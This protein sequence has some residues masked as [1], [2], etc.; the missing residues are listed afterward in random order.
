MLLC[1]F[2][3]RCLC[4]CVCFFFCFAL[5]L[6]FCS[7]SCS[8]ISFFSLFLLAALCAKNKINYILKTKTNKIRTTSHMSPFTL[9]DL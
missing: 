8:S 1:A 9:Y 3:F 5:C 4:M 7:C 2:I 6:Y